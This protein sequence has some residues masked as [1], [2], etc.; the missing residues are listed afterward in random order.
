MG[1]NVLHA[2]AFQDNYIWF[3][4]AN[5]AELTADGKTKCIVVDPGDADATEAGLQQHRLQPVAI[6]CTHRHGDHVG[7]AAELVEKYHVPVYGPASEKIRAVDH[8]LNGGEIVDIEDIGQFKV[9]FTPGHTAGH[10]CYVGGGALFCGDTIFLCGCGRLF[11]GTARQL[12][13]SLRDLAELPGDTRIYCAHEYTLSNLAFAQ[14]VEPENIDLQQAGEAYRK[15]RQQNQPTPPS[16][17]ERER[18][19]NPF[20][21]VDRASVQSA[22][23]KHAGHALIEP[24]EV[25][26]ELRRWKDGFTG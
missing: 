1:I 26:T 9:L 14:T 10:I 20:F 6:F 3:I 4:T 2:C 24:V 17:I 16:T 8:P 21:R 7:G 13:T 15:M 5:E 11:D 18:A 25:F 19:V 23:E 12:Y 22:V